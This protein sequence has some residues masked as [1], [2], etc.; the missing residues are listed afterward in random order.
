MESRMIK[1]IYLIV[2]PLFSIFTYAGHN[3]MNQD[4]LW[5]M[6]K[7]MKSVWGKQ[8]E[9]VSK[10]FNQPLINNTQEKED[11][12]T[13][14]PFTL[15]D[16]TRISNV[17]VRLWGNGDNS[18]SLVSFV[19]NQPCITLDQ[20]KSHFPDL[21]LSN[22]PRGNTPGQSVGYRTP[23]DERGLAWAFSFPVLNQECLGRVVMSRYEQ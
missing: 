15:T 2:L 13:S 12:Y 10:L 8:V 22:I 18:V 1:A 17:D 20:V 14:A 6:I 4:S 9:D 21:K 19:V 3:K 16:G 5:Q 23:T 11:R 7:E